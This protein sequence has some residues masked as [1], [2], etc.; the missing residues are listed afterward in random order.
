[1]WARW[2]SLG[3]VA[4]ERG[5]PSR[6]RERVR[7]RTREEAGERGKEGWMGRGGREGEKEGRDG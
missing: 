1:M 3:E 4:G 2:E 7:A 6:R 5:T